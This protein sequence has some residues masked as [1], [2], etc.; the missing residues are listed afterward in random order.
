M[1]HHLSDVTH[2][3][4]SHLAEVLSQFSATLSFIVCLEL[5]SL[6]NEGLQLIWLGRTGDIGW[7]RLFHQFPS[8][9]ALHVSFELACFVAV[10]LEGITGDMVAEVLPNLELICFQDLSTLITGEINSS[11]RLYVG[12]LVAL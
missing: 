8:I 11:L 5:E 10:V 2:R 6:I 1:D 9:Q 7:L 3:H 4:V 12:P